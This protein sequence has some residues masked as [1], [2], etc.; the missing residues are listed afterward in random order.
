MQVIFGG[1]LNSQLG[2]GAMS[3]LREGSITLKNGDE[4]HPELLLGQAFRWGSKIAQ[5][6][7]SESKD[8]E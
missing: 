3:L 6:S 8:K 4:E 1:D 2:T 7:D 5:S